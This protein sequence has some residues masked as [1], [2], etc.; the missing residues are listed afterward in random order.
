MPEAPRFEK[1]DDALFVDDFS[2]PDL[3]GWDADRGGVWKVEHG[4]LRA[5][6]PDRKHQRSLL[7]AGKSGWT[8]YAVDLDVCMTRGVDKGIAVRVKGDE[9]VGVDLRGP[10]YDD[11]LLHSGASQ[12]GRASVRNP[13]GQWHHLR[14]EARGSR[15]RVFVN[16]R[17]L[18]EAENSDRAR[19]GIALAAYTG[20]VAKC[21]VYYDNLAVTRIGAGRK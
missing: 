2:H 5:R 13:N 14:I 6:L 11:V 12:L 18:I 1:P 9:G 20:G 17:P 7:R 8:D 15:Y 21:T 10:G 19:G 3:R 16:G 4:M